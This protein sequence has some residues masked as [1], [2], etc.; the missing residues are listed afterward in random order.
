[1]TDRLKAALDELRSW[2]EASIDPPYDK[3]SMLAVKT[4]LDY[5]DNA[6]E[7]ETTDLTDR[8]DMIA[9]TMIAAKE[10]VNIADRLLNGL[11]GVEARRKYPTEDDYWRAVAEEYV[12]GLELEE[13]ND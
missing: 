13:K 12:K 8:E 3:D 4:V 6:V 10:L 11:T 1:M 7:V 2:Y 9:N 5:F